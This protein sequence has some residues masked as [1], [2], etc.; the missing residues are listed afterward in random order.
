MRPPSH[1]A[2]R[3]RPTLAANGEDASRNARHVCARRSEGLA[4]LGTTAVQ[5]EK[6]LRATVCEGTS[7]PEF[8]MHKQTNTYTLLQFPRDREMATEVY[9]SFHLGAK[10]Y[11]VLSEQGTGR[12]EKVHL[13][14]QAL[15]SSVLSTITPGGGLF[16]FGIWSLLYQKIPAREKNQQTLRK[17]FHFFFSANN[18]RHIKM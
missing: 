8:F 13:Y 18:S 9:H 15:L 17:Q 10:R 14:L 6:D 11:G 3:H 16:E 7:Q 5:W 1:P 4:M 12:Y 2:S